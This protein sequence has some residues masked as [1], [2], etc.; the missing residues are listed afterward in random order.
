VLIP[1]FDTTEALRTEIEHFIRCLTKGERPIVGGEEALRI[2][3]VLA[4]AEKS[5]QEAGCLVSLAD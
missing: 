4:A 1:Q 3:Q 2:V 5:I